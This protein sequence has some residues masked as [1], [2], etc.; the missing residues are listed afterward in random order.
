MRDINDIA[1]MVISDVRS[2]SQDRPSNFTKE[3]RAPI[4]YFFVRLSDIYG[5]EY[6]RQ[7]PDMESETRAKREWGDSLKH[8]DRAQLDK[9]ID[10][11]KKQLINSEDNWQFLNVGRCVGAIREATRSRDA[12]KALPAPEGK[13]MEKGDALSMIANMRDNLDLKSAEPKR[14][15]TT[16]IE[17][18]LEL[19]GKA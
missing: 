17:A 13:R 18:E 6:K 2:G 3:E 9:G 4:A 10:F 19:K 8:Y 5:V 7:L 12:H 15:D 14:I 1:G 16:A 11:I